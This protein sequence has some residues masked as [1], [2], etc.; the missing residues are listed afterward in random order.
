MEQNAQQYSIGQWVV[1]SQYGV[2]QIKQIERVPL[3]GNMEE[4][5]KCF[6]VQTKEGV[7]W[8]PVNQNDNPRVRPITSEKKFKE[9]G[10]LYAV[11]EADTAPYRTDVACSRGCAFCCKDAGRIDITTVEGLIIRKTI[12]RMPRSRQ[13]QVKKALA[14]DMKKRETGKPSAC[15]FLQKNKACM[16]YPVRPFACRRVYSLHVCTQAQ[17]PQVHR[18]VMA[19]AAET[20]KALQRL[21]DNGYSGHLSYVLHMLD[22][23]RFMQIF[24]KGQSKPE[25]VMAFGKS[26]GI[27]INKMVV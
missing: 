15:P 25:E 20:V 3:H 7:F 17:P 2:G 21:D 11:F 19:R 22:A 14:R 10:R 12:D 4:K 13:T 16:I 27:V 23:P 6:T 5:E 8:F 26:H 1:H 18:Q 9:V 24:L